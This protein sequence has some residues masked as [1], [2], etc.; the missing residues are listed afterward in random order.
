MANGFKPRPPWNYD[1]ETDLNIDPSSPFYDPEAIEGGLPSYRGPAFS[2]AP[3]PGG[4]SGGLGSGTTTLGGGSGATTLGGGG[5]L[6]IGRPRAL[7]EDPSRIWGSYWAGAAGPDWRFTP[8]LS[9]MKQDYESPIRSAYQ[10]ES[11][12]RFLAGEA[13]I[14]FQ[15]WL[16]DPSLTGN[17]W[18]R[19]YDPTAISRMA[20]WAARHPLN[21]FMDT[22]PYDLT[23]FGDFSGLDAKFI[24]DYFDA[25][26]GAAWGNLMSQAQFNPLGSSPM[27][28]AIARARQM[29]EL[30]WMQQNPLATPADYYAYAT[31]GRAPT[32]LVNPAWSFPN[33]TQVAT[34]ATNAPSFAD[35]V[36]YLAA[37]MGRG[38]D[39]RIA[40][41]SFVGNEETVMPANFKP[42]SANF[43]GN[44][45]V[46]IR[47]MSTD[48]IPATPGTSLQPS[49]VAGV[50]DKLKSG[51]TAQ[52]AFRDPAGD[53]TGRIPE[54]FSLTASA[55]DGPVWTTPPEPDPNIG[56]W[57]YG[58][59]ATPVNWDTAGAGGFRT[60]TSSQDGP[61]I[62]VATRTM[63]FGHDEAMRTFPG[64]KPLPSGI[65]PE[66]A[67]AENEKLRK[68]WEE[69]T[70]PDN[71]KGPLVLPYPRGAEGIYD[72]MEM[73]GITW[74]YVRGKDGVVQWMK[75]SEYNATK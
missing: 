33:P 56:G 61:G 2:G 26:E 43:G 13:A 28:K 71:E 44:A 62:D 70:R 75:E 45:N 24:R 27:G 60:R 66:M 10:Q 15:D 29:H 40:P 38:N 47:Q 72:Q 5:P 54:G 65:N 53:A 55:T 57:S 20:M 14:G 8:G 64:S 58:G 68:L 21:E 23:G 17:M 63:P 1:P 12:R 34:A 30:D 11:L 19:S 3:P 6:G 16:S 73:G 67:K 50:M 9:Q 7:E 69:D 46:P 51:L 4:I 48:F 36:N 37:S 59:G 39:A 35:N 25:N 49:S 22:N 18:E 32:G 31:S 41:T 74:V 52:Q 42:I